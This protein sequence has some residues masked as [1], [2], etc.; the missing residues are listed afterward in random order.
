M[1]EPFIRPCCLVLIIVA[2]QT[3]VARSF[4]SWHCAVLVLTDEYADRKRK[5]EMVVV[6]SEPG[7]V[8]VYHA[9]VSLAEPF[10]ITDE[11]ASPELRPFITI[12]EFKHSWGQ[13]TIV[14]SLDTVYI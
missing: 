10:Q 6:E 11:N 5:S 9:S 7:I 3:T 2:W 12:E 8:H 13:N 14:S 1:Y 4:T